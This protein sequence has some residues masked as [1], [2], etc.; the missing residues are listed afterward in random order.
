MARVCYT[1]VGSCEFQ[2]F[3][4]AA[5]NSC[6]CVHFPQAASRISSRCRL[7]FPVANCILPFTPSQFLRPQT[8]IPGPETF[9][10][11]ARDCSKLCQREDPH[12]FEPVD[13][14]RRC[15]GEAAAVLSENQSPFVE[16]QCT[17]RPPPPPA[18]YVKLELEQ[19]WSLGKRKYFGSQKKNRKSN[20]KHEF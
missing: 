17:P 3:T 18:F 12:I 10:L 8:T 4:L 7:H 11:S 13:S 19:F 20:Q 16:L 14:A 9:L 1:Q 15:W 6:V 2:I 5:G